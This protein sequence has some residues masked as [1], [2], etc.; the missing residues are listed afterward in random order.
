MRAACR[1]QPRL[2]S[3]HHQGH[4]FPD[5]AVMIFIAYITIATT[6][7]IPGLTPVR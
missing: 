4:T 1:S 7:V 5:H 2:A 3:A 6:L